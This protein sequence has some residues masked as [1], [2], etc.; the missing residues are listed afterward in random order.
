MPKQFDAGDLSRST[1]INKR[2][3]YTII[4]A[5]RSLRLFLWSIRYVRK[6]NFSNWKQGSFNWFCSSSHVR[7]RTYCLVKY[8]NFFNITLVE[9]NLSA[10]VVLWFHV[11]TFLRKYNCNLFLFFEL[12]SKTKTNRYPLLRQTYRLA[13]SD[14]TCNALESFNT[15]NPK[16]TT[17]MVFLMVFE[18]FW[19]TS[20]GIR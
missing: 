14:K 10:I 18:R 9:N 11:G 1:I 15:R 12:C 13:G 3:V 2:T 17:T 8:Q 7:Y 16:S 6:D 5:G 20:T 4:F 19:G